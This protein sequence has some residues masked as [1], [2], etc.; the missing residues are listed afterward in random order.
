M[1]FEFFDTMRKHDHLSLIYTVYFSELEI[2]GYRPFQ[3]VLSF[4]EETSAKPIM[5][6]SALLMSVRLSFFSLLVCEVVFDW[7][8]MSLIHKT[9]TTV[10]WYT[11][12][13]CCSTNQ[14]QGS[15]NSPHSFCL[16]I[17]ANMAEEEV[18]AVNADNKNGMCKVGDAPRAVIPSIVDP[19]VSGIMVSMD[20]KDSNSSDEVQ[21][22]RRNV[23]IT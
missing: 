11:C 10:I 20:Q 22:K 4:G 3:S 23:K 8:E 5:Q 12:R 17:P 15:V 19:K 13:P 21:S 2:F 18:A 14:D 1:H 9:L 7:T 16:F 6:R